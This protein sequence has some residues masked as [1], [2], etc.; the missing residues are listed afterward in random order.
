MQNWAAWGVSWLGSWGNS[1]GPIEVEEEIH[2]GAGHPSISA[3]VAPTGIAKKHR[4]DDFVNKAVRE[5]YEG[6]TKKAPQKIKKQ[7]AKIVK[8]F[9]V[10]GVRPATIPPASIIDWKKLEKDAEKVSSLLALWQE[11]MDMEEEEMLLMLMAA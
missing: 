6:I 3:F 8:P 7:A 11:Q 2:A 4:I 1:W 9:I 5:L 10:D